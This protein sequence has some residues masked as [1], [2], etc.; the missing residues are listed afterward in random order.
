MVAPTNS[1]GNVDRQPLGGLVQSAVDLARDHCG[2][3]ERQLE[4]LPPH[5]LDENGELEL[6]SAPDLPG[7]RAAGGEDPQRDVANE[8]G[9]ETG[10]DEPRGQG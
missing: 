2:F 4:A 3:A 9:I 5:D 6:A 7:V 10:L 8:L 1:S